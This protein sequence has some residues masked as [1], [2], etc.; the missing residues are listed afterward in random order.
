MNHDVVMADGDKNI[1]FFT[2]DDYH[3]KD[4]LKYSM[5]NHRTT[6]PAG[7]GLGSRQSVAGCW[8][9]G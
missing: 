2:D 9:A 1:F 8:L 3:L 5:Y 6:L 4:H 7:T